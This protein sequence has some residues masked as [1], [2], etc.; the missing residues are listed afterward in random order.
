LQRWQ[1]L[2]GEQG[3][4]VL[5]DINDQ[6]EEEGGNRPFRVKNHLLDKPGVKRSE[7]QKGDGRT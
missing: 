2:L 6:I 7:W 4:N 1:N 5:L 3:S